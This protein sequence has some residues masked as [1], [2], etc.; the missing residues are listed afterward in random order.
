[1]CFAGNEQSN[2]E[3]MGFDDSGRACKMSPQVKFFNHFCCPQI[4][5]VVFVLLFNTCLLSSLREDTAE[6]SSNA[7]LCSRTLIRIPEPEE[8]EKISPD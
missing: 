3:H 2:K 1:M 8:R 7:E 5:G 6:L 4:A